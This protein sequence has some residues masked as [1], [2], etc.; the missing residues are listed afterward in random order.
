MAILRT[1]S[2]VAVAGLIGVA[3]I[4]PIC[5][6]PAQA[7]A[8]I[9]LEQAVKDCR[10]IS[11]K[12]A[13]LGCYDRAI[14]A[15]NAPPPRQS[16]VPA[17]PA[18]MAST[19]PPAPVALATPPASP[20]PKAPPVSAAPPAAVGSAMPPAAPQPTAP[21]ATGIDGIAVQIASASING[22]RVLSVVTSSGETWSQ[23]DSVE[24]ARVPQAGETMMITKNVFGKRMCH[25]ER[26][27][28]F[29][30]KSQK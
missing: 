9:T 19:T 20:A 2:G 17:P 13:R 25:I 27:P 28:A 26:L 12:A 15:S 29:A 3:L 11:D 16:L 7:Q 30:C 18:P 4:V 22:N 1:M 6:G 24:F 5:A 10:L 21:S 14:D 8:M 23:T